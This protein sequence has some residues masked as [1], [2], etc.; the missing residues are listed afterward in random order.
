MPPDALQE[1][2]LHQFQNHRTKKRMPFSKTYIGKLGGT[3]PYL[4]FGRGT[5]KLVIFPP[6]NDALFEA[7]AFP[8]YL[9]FLFSGFAADYDVYIVSRK[10]TLPVGCST[11]DMAKDYAGILE[12]TIGLAHVIGISLGGMV[13]QYYAYD[14]PHLVKK[15]IIVS[16][17]HR[18]GPEG[19]EIAR[20]WIPWSKQGKWGEIYDETLEITYTKTH[21][22]VYRMIKSFLK[23]YLLPRIKDPFDFITSGYAGIIHDSFQILPGIKAPALIIGGTRD[24]FFPESLLQEMAARMTSAELFLIQGSGHGAFE[25]YRKRCVQKSLDF[26]RGAQSS[27]AFTAESRRVPSR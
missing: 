20:R 11:R 19:L 10:R 6:I 13:A 16:S 25:E 7:S 3:L 18:M 9:R 5:E 14:F 22:W 12:K 4:R 8:L 23:R 27:P 15:L 21:L 1:A 26:L 24:R 2:P 17:A